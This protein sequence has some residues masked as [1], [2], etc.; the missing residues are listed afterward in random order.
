RF[1]ITVGALP[2]VYARFGQKVSWLGGNPVFDVSFSSLPAML[3]A[4]ASAGTWYLQGALTDPSM[5]TRRYG[6]RA[7]V[8][9]GAARPP[10]PNG[11]GQSCGQCMGDNEICELSTGLCV[12]AGALPG[13]DAGTDAG[14]DQ[15]DAGDGGVRGGCG[16]GAGGPGAVV[17]LAALA[18]RR[19]GAR[20]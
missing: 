2:K 6:L 14:T 7:Q 4:Q 19:R 10:A 15:A 17:L 12:D 8:P 18:L 20:S 13:D 1:A 5:G 9:G 16:C 3:P 11:C